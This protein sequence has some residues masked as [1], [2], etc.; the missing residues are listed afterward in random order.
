MRRERDRRDRF[1]LDLAMLRVRDVC[2][3]I[4]LDEKQ[5]GLKPAT[6]PVPAAIRAEVAEPSASAARGLGASSSSS[7]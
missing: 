5:I 7:R 1:A 2:G 4:A 6:A 3:W